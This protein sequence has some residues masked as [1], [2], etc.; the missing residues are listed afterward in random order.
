MARRAPEERR[1]A[2]RDPRAAHEEGQGLGVHRPERTRPRCLRERHGRSGDLRRKRRDGRHAARRSALA[3]RRP[4][5]RRTRIAGSCRGS[6]RRP[7]RGQLD[8]R[9]PGLRAAQRGLRRAG[10]DPAEAR[11]PRNGGPL[12][13]ADRARRRRPGRGLGALRLRIRRHRRS[14]Q[15]GRRT[16]GRPEREPPLH[17][18]TGPVRRSPG[19]SPPSAPRS[20]ATASSTGPRSDSAAATARSG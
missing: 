10:Q 17:R 3:A 1:L 5:R 18:D 15:H 7:Q 8:R 14:A 13:H 12:A 16:V 6:V 11:Q 4:G 20:N 9:R 2:G 19:C